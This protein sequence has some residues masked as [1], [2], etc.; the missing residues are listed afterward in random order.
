MN[1]NI[2]LIVI[3]IIILVAI[4]IGVLFFKTQDIPIVTPMITES[5]TTSPETPSP[6]PQHSLLEQDIDSI[7]IDDNATSNDFSDLDAAI[8]NI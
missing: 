1:K 7:Q 3:L 6:T 8:G 2:I 4:S 5:P